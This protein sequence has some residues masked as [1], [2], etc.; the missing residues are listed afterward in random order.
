M[1]E[2]E[3]PFIWLRNSFHINE[4]NNTMTKKI[5][6]LLILIYSFAQCFQIYYMFKNFNMNLLIRYGP[7]IILFILVILVATLF[8]YIEQDMF[9]ALTFFDKISWSFSMIREDAQI[10]LKRKCLIINI[11]I[12]FILLLV[13]TTITIGA[14]YFGNQRELF[15]C[16]QIFEEYFGKWSPIPYYFYFVGFPFLYYNFFKAWTVFVYGILEVQLQFNLVEEY[17]IESNKINDFKGW[18]HLQDTRYQQE[19]GKSLQLCIT[20]HIA[21]KKL[22]NKIINFT[23]TGMPFF[24]VLGVSLLICSL[25]FIINFAHTMSNILKIRI[26]IFVATNVCLTIL[27]CWIGQQL[28]DATSNIFSS[29]VGA[30]WYFWNLKNTKTL[31]MFL[32]N[33]TKNDSIVLAGICL[34]Y[35]LFVSISRITVSYA[36]VLQKY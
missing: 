14:P 35:R 9:K 33:C 27:L 13:V 4:S 18:K 28:I 1:Y 2:F 8:L 6:V 7:A 25:A 31:L 34:D 10:R 3:D 16:I 12:L 5:Y 29:L 36:L 24:L 23:M 15:I 32:I 26:L 20:H 30:P 17:L 11:C 21:L 22:V 19:I